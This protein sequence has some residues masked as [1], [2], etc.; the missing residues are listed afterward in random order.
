MKRIG[1]LLNATADSQNIVA[2]Y[3]DTVRRKRKTRGQQ[4]AIED[5]KANLLPNLQDV[6]RTIMSGDWHLHEN[7][8]FVRVEHGKMRNVSW[9]PSIKDNVIQHAIARTAG[10]VLEKSCISDTYSG[11]TKRGPLKGKNRMVSYLMDY[12]DDQPIY[13]LK[14]DIRHYYE[15]ID[16]SKLKSMIRRKIKDKTILKLLDALIDSHPQGLP[17]GNFLSQ[18]LANYYLSPLD[19]FIKEQRGFRHYGR[20]CDD[21][22]VLSSDKNAL[23]RLLADI[24]AFLAD[25]GLEVK[26]NAQIFPIER[27]GVDFMGYVFHRHT[28]TL[29]K[30]IERHLRRAAHLFRKRPDQRHYATLASL[31]GW[32]KHIT[33]ADTFWMAVVGT[34]IKQL[35]PN[36]K[37][38]TTEVKP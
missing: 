13:V 37:K 36:R 10:K 17:I 16:T 21:I 6:Q 34:P 14:I 9:N 20:Y 35:N 29:R 8:S 28:T 15:S 11:F 1:N 3:L 23:K 31:Y 38:A 2:A 33:K 18:T 22:V 4:R 25:Y 30:R 7:K 27:N 19:R 26:A 24:K 12:S 5:F 32:S